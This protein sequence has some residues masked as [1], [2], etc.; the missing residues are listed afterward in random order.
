MVRIVFHLGLQVDDSWK[1]E[2]KRVETKS[3]STPS[4]SLRE[5]PSASFGF[6]PDVGLARSCQEAAKDPEIE[7]SRSQQRSVT[8]RPALS[9]CT[10]TQ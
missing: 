1:T 9:D 4:T 2:V 7:G 5:G 6:P 3:K 8:N 10:K